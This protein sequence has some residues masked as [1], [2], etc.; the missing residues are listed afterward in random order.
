MNHEV[1]MNVNVNMPQFV[2]IGKCV[3]V[4][5]AIPSLNKLTIFGILEIPDTN[6]GTSNI[7]GSQYNNVVLNV[8]YISIQVRI[9]TSISIYYNILKSCE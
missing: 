2:F 9:E 6:N 3:I 4:D 5:I 1:A 8:T 7:G